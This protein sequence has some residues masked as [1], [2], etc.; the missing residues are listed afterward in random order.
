MQEDY[1]DFIKYT[2][3]VDVQGCLVGILF[4]KSFP[5]TEEEQKAWQMK[6]ERWKENEQLLLDGMTKMKNA[7]VPPRFGRL[8]CFGNTK[9]IIEEYSTEEINMILT[10][11]TQK[12][13]VHLIALFGSTNLMNF[14]LSKV[15]APLLLSQQD[16]TTLTPIEY[17]S[18]SGK[19]DL[20]EKIIF[21]TRLAASYPNLSQFHQCEEFARTWGHIR[22]ANKI[23][24]KYIKPANDP[25]RI[26]S[27]LD[28]CVSVVGAT[29]NKYQCK[30]KKLVRRNFFPL[31]TKFVNDD[32]TQEQLIEGGKNYY[33]CMASILS[34]SQNIMDKLMKFLIKSCPEHCYEILEQLNSLPPLKVD[35]DHMIQSSQAWEAH[36]KKIFDS[37]LYHSDQP[38]LINV[39]EQS[40]TF[41]LEPEDDFE[42]SLGDGKLFPKERGGEI[43]APSVVT[44]EQFKLQFRAFTSDLLEKIDW[45]GMVVFGGAVLASLLPLPAGVRNDY[46]SI[47]KHYNKDSPFKGSDIDL[48]IYNCDPFQIVTKVTKI[49]RTLQK[50]KQDHPG[51]DLLVT[52]SDHVITFSLFYPYRN[53][54]ISVGK[55]VNIFQILSFSDL[56]SSVFAFDGTNVWTLPRGRLSINRK[57]NF[58]NLNKKYTSKGNTLVLRAL[59]YTLRGFSII[60]PGYKYKDQLSHLRG[61]TKEEENMDIEGLFEVRCGLDLLIK[62]ERSPFLFDRMVK[63]TKNRGLPYGPQW[64]EFA[65]R[66]LLRDVT[67]VLD[68]WEK[69]YIKIIEPYEVDHRITHFDF[70]FN[71]GLKQKHSLDDWVQMLKNS[72]FDVDEEEDVDN[73]IY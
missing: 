40:P 49:Y 63:Y 64:D 54:Q 27:L 60:V 31:E 12:N 25:V 10:E 9:K 46:K 38:T 18:I 58:L 55:F 59:K 72:Q 47:R 37:Y 41:V 17:A 26:P 44:Y 71:F 33:A 48:Y 7:T 23:N 56:D 2:Q 73:D 30:D 67:S 35:M 43:G 20:F 70:N 6:Q 29:L 3:L 19:M 61:L 52:S 14:F 34:S 8:K 39:Y 45:S 24:R 15:P 36:W 66:Q 50:F 5:I 4:P 22:T 13:V 42:R 28:I 32:S 51:A 68:Y 62:V 16:I 11:Y 69:E 1:S 65:Y 53:I 57:W 21:F